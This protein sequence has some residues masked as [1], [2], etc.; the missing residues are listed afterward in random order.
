MIFM[1]Y[2]IICL[3]KGERITIILIENF[4]SLPRRAQQSRLTAE[5]RR[6]TV[7]KD[8]VSAGVSEIGGLFNTTEIRILICYILTAVGEPVPGQMLANELHFAGIANCF[9][10]NDAID[11]LCKSGH[12]KASEQTDDEY[13]ITDSGR[14]IAE[15]LKTSLPLTVRDRAYTI[16]LKLVS[17]YKTAKESDIQISHEDGKTF[18]TCSAMDSGVP[19]ISVRLLVSDEDQAIFMK[20]K[21]LNNGKIYSEIIDL[22]TK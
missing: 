9:E 16:A 6:V 10:V 12:I 14:D 22:L 3:Q 8:A 18:V 15:T 21:F 1:V 7:E 19:F 20:N 17:R 4:I 2:R 13:S 11:S 5:E